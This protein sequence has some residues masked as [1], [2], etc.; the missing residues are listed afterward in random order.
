MNKNYTSAPLPFQGQKRNFVKQFK[1]ALKEYPKN[2]V[3]VDLFGGSG[4][5]SHVAK[6]HNPEA[7][8]VYN[9]YDDFKKRLNAISETNRLISELRVLFKSLNKNEK[10]PPLLK[11]KALKVVKKYANKGFVDYV[12]LSA[13]V[14]FSMN[15]VTSFNELE[16]QTFY[17]KVRKSNYKSDNYLN[18]VEFVRNDY[19]ELFNKYKDDKNVVFLVDPPYL[20]TD[21]KTYKNYWKLTDYLDVLKVLYHHNYFYFTS[22]KSSIVELCKWIEDNTGGV[23]PFKDS[24][25]VYH[26]NSTTHNSGYN[27]IMLHK[28]TTTTT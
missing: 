14:L 20:S 5:L 17:N 9:D 22:N 23:N 7:T 12:T 11:N 15:Y 18:G 25:I 2:A 26:Y 6:S 27:D 4:L 28:Y 8:V 13:N 10:L 3:Y 1:E 19:K 16:K 24:K 21:C